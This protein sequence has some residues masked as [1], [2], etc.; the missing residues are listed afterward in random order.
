MKRFLTLTSNIL[1]VLAI[2]FIVCQVLFTNELAGITSQ[3]H[4]LDNDLEVLTKENVTL[5]R[6]VA[7]ESSS[8]TVSEKAKTL[9]FVEAKKI[10][11]LT[12]K[13]FQVALQLPR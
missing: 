1:P 12:E 7:E 3:L 9:G 8:V 13:D 10:M 6:Q 11:T 5:K 2:G 4:A